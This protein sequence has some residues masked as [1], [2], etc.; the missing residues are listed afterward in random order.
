M[1]RVLNIFMILLIIFFLYGIYEYYSSSKNI[2]LKKYNRTNIE[3]ILK[4]KI[5]DLPVLAND[6]N[7]VIEFNNSIE[8]RSNNEKNRSFWELLKNKWN[9]KP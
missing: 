4:E 3:Q 1:N 6:T 7:N 9:V 2:T 8:N 5:S